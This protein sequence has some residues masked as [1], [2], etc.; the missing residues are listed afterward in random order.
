MKQVRFKENTNLVV[1]VTEEGL[2]ISPEKQTRKGWEQQFK[3]SKKRYK[4]PSLL[5]EFPNDFDKDKWNF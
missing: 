1:K 5:G 4:N 3:S 2:L